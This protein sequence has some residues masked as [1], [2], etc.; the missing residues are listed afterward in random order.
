M[1]VRKQ[2][3]NVLEKDTIENRERKRKEIDLDIDS[4]EWFQRKKRRTF[5]RRITK[6][7]DVFR[8]RMQKNEREK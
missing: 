6:R 2:K 1:T 7:W 8:E 3:K 5:Q 4:R